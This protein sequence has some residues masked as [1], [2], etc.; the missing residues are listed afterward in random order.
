MLRQVQTYLVVTV[1]T[2]LIWILAESESVRTETLRTDVVLTADGEGRRMIQIEPDQDFS[3]VVLLR[4]EGATGKID[5]LTRELR[6]AL[7]LS[8]PMPGLPAEPGEHR[9][10]LRTV[11]RAFP[12][13][14]D[15]GVTLAEVDPPFVNVRIDDIVAREARV[16]VKTP[17]AAVVGTPTSSPSSVTIRMP[18][19]LAAQ[20][21]LTLEVSAVI[22]PDVIA[23]LPEGKF[24]TVPNVTLVL[25]D[26][27]R[28]GPGSEFVQV[29]P[30]QVSVNLTPRSREAQKL[31]PS[32]PV[33][34]VIPTTE[35]ARWDIT[36]QETERSISDVLVSGPS[37]LIDQIGKTIFI[38]ALVQFQGFGEL[39]NA[40][41]TGQPLVK[42]VTFSP[43]PGPLKFDAKDRTVTLMV[44]PRAES[45]AT[46]GVPP[47]P[48]P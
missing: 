41:R 4:L 14:R 18:S 40:A 16:V 31:L 39:D 2:V 19:R 24:A 36:I 35:Y 25:P 12:A 21:S 45:E 13:I 1:V 15:S 29:E 8:P 9:I 5:A 37:D 28:T 30:P 32:V 44:R 43:L 7:R 22:G 11:L 38:V 47:S 6:S 20:L 10:D 48:A 3:G 23:A 34:F 27:V 33:Q 26:S 42:E 17:E 46:P